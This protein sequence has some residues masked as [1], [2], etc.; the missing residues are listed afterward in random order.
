[1]RPVSLLAYPTGQQARLQAE[2]A[3]AAGGGEVSAGDVSAE[4]V[5]ESGGGR[6]VGLPS[7]LDLSIVTC[8]ADNV[9]M[10]VQAAMRSADGSTT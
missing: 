6:A 3:A 8:A 2:A 9:A 10:G 5:A 1:M 4:E 7:T